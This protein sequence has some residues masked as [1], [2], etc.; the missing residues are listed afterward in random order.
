MEPTTPTS[1]CTPGMSLKQMNRAWWQQYQQHARSIFRSI[2]A[3][4]IYLYWV[5]RNSHW[6]T[7]VTSVTRQVIIENV[8]FIQCMATVEENN[9]DFIFSSWYCLCVPWSNC[10]PFY[11]TVNSVAHNIPQWLTETWVRPF[12]L[13]G[14]ASHTLTITG[15][16]LVPQSLPLSLLVFCHYKS[17]LKHWRIKTCFIQGAEIQFKYNLFYPGFLEICSHFALW[18]SGLL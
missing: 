6:E 13:W 17:N 9:L 18:N 5:S 2:S 11:T 8:K 7:S 4:L 15:N 3:I 12:V 10:L 14:E 16:Q 1:T